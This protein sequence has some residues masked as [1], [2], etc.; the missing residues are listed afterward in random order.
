MSVELKLKAEGKKSR[1][2]IHVRFE[3]RRSQSILAIANPMKILI[4]LAASNPDIEM[5]R[6]AST[7]WTVILIDEEFPQIWAVEDPAFGNG[8]ATRMCGNC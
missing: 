7:G 6:A 4:C 2:K 1:F 3:V 5:R 8:G